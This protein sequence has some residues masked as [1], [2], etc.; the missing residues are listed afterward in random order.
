MHCIFSLDAIKNIDKDYFAR[1]YN[2]YPKRL[3]ISHP[4]YDGEIILRLNEKPKEPIE[5][6]TGMILI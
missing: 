5:M 1:D 6:D 3:V 4:I 2:L